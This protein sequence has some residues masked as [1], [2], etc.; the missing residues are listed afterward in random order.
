MN[1]SPHNRTHGRMPS[2]AQ[3]DG[4]LRDFFRLETPTELNLPFRRTTAAD[5][6]GPMLTVIHE[7]GEST[8]PIRRNQRYAVVSALAVLALSLIVVVQTRDNQTSGSGPVTD[9]VRG[10]QSP[11][12]PD[13]NLMLVSPQGDSGAHKTAVGEDGVTLE[14]TDH[15]E[16]KQRR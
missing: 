10:P 6:S 1:D 2:D 15:I 5:S 8:V 4:L 13:E 12:E 7:T 14:E 9:T 3:M 16:V 11:V